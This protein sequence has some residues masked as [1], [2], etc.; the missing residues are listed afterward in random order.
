MKAQWDLR[1]ADP[2][3]STKDTQ[4]DMFAAAVLAD[5]RVGL[6]ADKL[7]AQQVELK[8]DQKEATRADWLA[9]LR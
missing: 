1:S 5:P 3:V 4:M 7:V 6:K 2:S 8:A 9:A